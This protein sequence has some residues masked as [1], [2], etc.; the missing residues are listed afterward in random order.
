MKLD[1]RANLAE[2]ESIIIGLQ[3]DIEKA[4][5]QAEKETVRFARKELENRMIA[6]TGIPAVAFRR[7]RV[8]SKNRA[9]YGV[10]WLGLRPIAAAYLGKLSQAATGAKAGIYFFEGAFVANVKAGKAGAFHH[11]VFKR[12][13]AGRLPIDEQTARLEVGF[14]VAED[15]AALSAVE[16]RRRFAD[17]LRLANPHIA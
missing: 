4:Q 9:D 14:E 12:R 10:V 2:T 1:I 8:K 13:G 6:R 5:R 16:L 17:H 7:F 11:S 15:V 3:R